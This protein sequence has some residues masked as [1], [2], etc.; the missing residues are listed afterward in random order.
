MADYGKDSVA[1]IGMM[2]DKDCE[3]FLK[4]VMPYCKAAV[5]VTVNENPRSISAENLKTLA[6]KYCDSVVAA[7]DYDTAIKTAFQIAEGKRPL[8]VCGSLYLA[9]SLREKLKN[10]V[11]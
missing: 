5:T 4:R 6:E 8:F 9:C 1:L 11:K 10:T 7:S 3:L 2:A